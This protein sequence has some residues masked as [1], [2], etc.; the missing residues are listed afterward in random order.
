MLKERLAII[1]GGNMGEAL[2]KGLLEAK[3]FSTDQITVVEV[4][5]ERSKYIRDNYSIAVTDN[6]IAAASQAQIIL[7][8]VKPQIMGAVLDDF[9]S[10][11]NPTQL[12]ISIA[13]GIKIAFLKAK[14]GQ[15]TRVVRVMPNT[16]AL[17]QAG[18]SAVCG[19]DASDLAVARTIFKAVG[20]VVEVEEKLMDAVTALSGSGPAYVFVVIE[21]LADAGVSLGLSRSVA[22]ELAA[23]TVNGSAKLLIERQ[24]HPAKLKDM[25]TSPGGTTIAGLQVLEEGGLRAT[26]IA[27]VQAAAQRSKELAG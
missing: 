21:A 17:I 18:V 20:Q 23:R 8:A 14:L 26:L 6:A 10:A 16:P 3:T 27:A 2:L 1:G 5:N 24:E 11:V 4:N 25:V 19:D 15:N 9:A 7:L 12:V 22:L 13:A